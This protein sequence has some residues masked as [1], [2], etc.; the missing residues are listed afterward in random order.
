MK[1]IML[2]FCMVFLFLTTLASV[3][4]SQLFN[5]TGDFSVSARIDSDCLPHPTVFTIGPG[6]QA[7][8]FE[9]A[10]ID[11]GKDC[12]LGG[13]MDTRGF[14]LRGEGVEYRYSKYKFDT[15][16]VMGG[17][18]AALVLGPGEYTLLVGGGD[19]AI[20]TLNFTIA[21][22]PP[23]APPA[24]PTGG[25]FYRW[26]RWKLDPPVETPVPRENLVL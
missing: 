7:T 17:P 23:G 24:P 2:A 16:V 12:Y 11:P 1:K 13:F 5:Q 25:V 6:L 20:V 10:R 19:G 18:L 3:A 22:A 15:P 14:T 9:I 8:N 21:A 26:S 4:D